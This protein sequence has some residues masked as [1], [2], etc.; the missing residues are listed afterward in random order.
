MKVQGMGARG[1]GVNGV[2]GRLAGCSSE[3]TIRSALSFSDDEELE[4]EAAEGLEGE[5]GADGRMHPFSGS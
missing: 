4:V 2:G 5:Q 3:M 1:G